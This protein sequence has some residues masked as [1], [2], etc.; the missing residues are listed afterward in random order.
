MKLSPEA[1]AVV[2][3][4]ALAHLV[5]LGADGRAHMTCAWVG[6]EDEEI[7]LG[8]LSDQKKLRNMRRDARVSLSIATD[9]I[10]EWG[11]TEYLVVNG[12]ARVTEGGAPELLQRLAHTYL[13]PDVTF[14]AMPNPPDGFVTRIAVDSVGGMGPWRAAE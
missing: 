2:E 14:P 11:L 6:L 13:G 8:T 1:R 10:N 9:R 7:V 12:T 4:D 5:T 3:S